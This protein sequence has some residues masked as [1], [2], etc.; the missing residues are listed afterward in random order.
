MQEEVNTQQPSPLRQ[1]EL[2][3]SET[4]HGITANVCQCM[5]CNGPHCDLQNH[6][7][8]LIVNTH[9]H[10][11]TICFFSMSEQVKKYDTEHLICQHQT[12]LFPT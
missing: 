10:K 11:Q 12:V 8:I 2:F 9:V 7:S 6:K 1:T 3:L 4:T 5:C